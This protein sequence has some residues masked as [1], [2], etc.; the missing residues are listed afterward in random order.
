[1]PAV[2]GYRQQRIRGGLCAVPVVLRQVCRYRMQQGSRFLVL[3]QQ[4]KRFQCH[5]LIAQV[6]AVGTVKLVVWLNGHGQVDNQLQAGF[7]LPGNFVGSSQAPAGFH[8]QVLKFLK[9]VHGA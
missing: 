1:M 7:R 3:A 2:L 9:A 5:G 8:A 4:N 6:G